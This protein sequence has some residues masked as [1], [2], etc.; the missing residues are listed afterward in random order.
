MFHGEWDLAW[1]PG[2]GPA[3]ARGV[4]GAGC[5]FRVGWRAAGGGG[6]V[7]FLFFDGFLLVLVGVSFWSGDW[8]LGYHSLDFRHFP[9]IS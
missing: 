7:K 4:F 6:V 5:S 9:D 2:A 1:V 8:A 3:V